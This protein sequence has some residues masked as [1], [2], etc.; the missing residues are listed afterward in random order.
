MITI[1]EINHLAELAEIRPLWRELLALTP[2][3]SFFQSLEW[4]ETYWQHFGAGKQLRVLVV[5][6]NGKPLG[7]RRG[8]HSQYSPRLGSVRAGMG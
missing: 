1:R 6:F 3:A 7:I 4:L 8:P 2:G 5:S